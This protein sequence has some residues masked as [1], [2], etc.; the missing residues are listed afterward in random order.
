MAT[1]PY[2]DVIGAFYS[3]VDSQQRRIASSRARGY[4]SDGAYDEAGRELL[5]YDT[6]AANA[7]LT[8]GDRAEKKAY[9]ESYADAYSRNDFGGM[10]RA[11][12]NYGDPSGVQT[13]RAAKKSYTEDQ[14]EDVRKKAEDAYYQVEQALKL[15]AEQQIGAYGQIRQKA[16]ADA[17][18]SGADA[19]ALDTIMP[20]SVSPQQLPALLKGL[21]RRA[22]G[23]AKSYDIDIDVAKVT[24]AQTKLDL[25]E[26]RVAE[27]R[28]GGSGG[29][30]R[31]QWRPMTPDEL[32]SYGMTT[33]GL[34]DDES[35]NVKAVPGGG[36]P[37]MLAGAE[38]RGRIVLSFPN[39]IQSL[40]DL[41]KIENAANAQG[42]A[43]PFG[44]DWGARMLEAVPF[45]GGSAARVAGG[46]DYTQYEAA[47]RTFEQSIMPAFSGSA[48]TESEA[49]RFV[50]ANN[51]RFG[52]NPAV[53]QKKAENRKRIT[54]SA[55]VIIGEQP[56][57]PE[58]GY[59]E[60]KT[61]LVKPA[62]APESQPGKA[63]SAP[64]GGGVVRWEKGPD[65]V[66][67]P[68]GAQ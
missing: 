59:W 45:D 12:V 68:V 62:G 53:L 25:D 21:Q 15:P 35:G 46:E 67:R 16:I 47:I 66:P 18:A 27:S 6:D 8:Y 38:Q 44:R 37:Q 17:T 19:R 64:A 57:Y 22:L 11:A 55:A 48:V 7:Y 10:E 43:T 23:L 31:A 49:Q 4:A 20:E 36:K 3:G 51:P 42:G 60:P 9:G 65:G 61:G 52:D 1:R 63:Q 29:G 40:E 56:P 2:A 28:G 26:R 39:I 32:T 58:V 41:D 34:I 13:S 30:S 24:Q 50:R 14:R 54:N 5:P 33:P